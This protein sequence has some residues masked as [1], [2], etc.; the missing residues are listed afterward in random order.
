MCRYSELAFSGM[1]TANGKMQR[2]RGCCGRKKSR[3]KLKICILTM[4]IIRIIISGISRVYA[5]ALGET[6]VG[7]RK[8]DFPLRNSQRNV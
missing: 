3:K 2:A 1:L 7:R 6:A 5:C 4:K 8:R